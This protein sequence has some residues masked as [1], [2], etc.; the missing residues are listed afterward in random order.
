[1]MKRPLR[2]LILLSPSTTALCRNSIWFLSQNQS[3]QVRSSSL[4]S[5]LFKEA[6]QQLRSA[7]V[8]RS[9]RKLV[10]VDEK[11]NN[12]YATPVDKTSRMVASTSHIKEIREVEYVWGNSH[13]DYVPGAIP[14]MWQS[15]LSGQRLELPVDQLD[16]NTSVLDESK[17]LP[18]EE[19]LKAGMPPPE[20]GPPKWDSGSSKDYTQ[21][22]G[23]EQLGVASSVQPGVADKFKPASWQP[24][25]SERHR[26]TPS[27]PPESV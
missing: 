13:H 23:E 10:G 9:G 27:A 2:R 18:N 19:L 6:A 1:M 22:A 25:V 16:T 4:F 5:R 20:L 17:D 7:L 14:I 21:V 12:Y 8:S 15:W 24:A 26:R 11:G 3:F